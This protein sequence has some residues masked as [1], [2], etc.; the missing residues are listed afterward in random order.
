MN[1]LKISIIFFV[2][3]SSLY[4][5]KKELTLQLKWK[6]QFQFAGYYAALHKGYY[7]EEGLDVIIKE[8]SNNMNMIDE[9]LSNNA[10]FGVGT[11]ELILDF[12]KNKPIVV[13]GVIFQHSPLGIMSLNKNIKTIHDLVGKNVMIEDGSADIYALLKREN[14]DINSLKILPHS[15]NVQNLI[16]N[17]VDAMSVYSIDEPYYLQQ[18]ELRYNIFS[19]RET[20][21]D[22]YGDNLF[23]SQN[24]IK[25]NPD[26]VEKF[27]R[28]SFKGWQY[29]M[30]NQDEIIEIIMKNYNT[31]NKAKEYYEFEAKKMMELIYPEILE[32]GYMQEGRWEHIVNIY[33]ELGFLNKDINLEKFMYS[34]HKTF[35]EQ[36]K[37][38]VFIILIFTVILLII[39]Y[40]AY[41][42]YRIN[43]KLIKSEQRHKIIFQNSATAGIVWKKGYIITDLNNQ[44][45]RL[46][47]WNADEVI[48]KNFM[49]FLIPENE[50]INFSKYAD[51]FLKNN[52]LHIFTNQNIMKNGNLI[53]CEWLNTRLP[54]SEFEDDF[55][56]VSLVM[57]I[58]QRLENEK[59]L[60][61]QAHYDFLTNLPNRNYFETIL[62]KIYSF[63]N[64]NNVSF[65]LAFI[66]LD[67][68]KN[69]ND[70]Y[71]HSAGDFLLQ[72]I[73]KR[74]QDNIR[75]EDTIS[76]IGGDE[77]AFIFHISNENENYEIFMNKLLSIASTPL[78]YTDNITLQVSASIGVTVYSEHN[79]VAIEELIKQADAAMYE[80]KRKGKN[81]FCD[82]SKIII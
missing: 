14:I 46:F 27:K 77:F 67:G 45:T 36:Y 25:Q 16:E 35:W 39:G 52:D 71:G 54:N 57:D 64:R 5:N 60:N 40:I 70:T 62:E 75:K 81:S 78:Q 72:E 23:T 68:F 6:H 9:V 19:P 4:G 74:F 7:K 56:V 10:Q 30:S 44:A 32:I 80:V 20:G 79:K 31:Q 34:S 51:V 28:A 82:S 59:V 15:F 53:T 47:G 55:E 50:K 1:I 18:K 11:S 66:D 3:L 41:Y 29:A 21:I 13:L 22:F 69:I 58:T 33:R 43:Q 24:M 17:K 38:I 12:A 73:S 65:G 61:Q 49:D 26:I 76:R 8:A 37:F 2:F 42:I 48:G 63:S